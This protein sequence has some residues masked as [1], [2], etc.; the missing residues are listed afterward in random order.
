LTI[1]KE[2]RNF[3]KQLRVTS[4]NVLWKHQFTPQKLNWFVS[5]A[6]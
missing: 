1:Q 6:V 3:V 4:Q 2:S 5:S